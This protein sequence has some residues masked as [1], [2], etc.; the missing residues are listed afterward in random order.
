MRRREIQIAYSKDTAS[1]RAAAAQEDLRR[2]KHARPRNGRPE[3]LPPGRRG[4]GVP[5]KSKRERSD[6]ATAAP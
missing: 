2:H 5:G 1:A 4:E 6:L 3:T